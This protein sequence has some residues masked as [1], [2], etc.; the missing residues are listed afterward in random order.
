VGYLTAPAGLEYGGFLFYADDYN[1]YLAKMRQG[2]EGAWAYR[3]PYTV[4]EHDGGA[5]YL[6]YLV[7]GRLAA[8][9]GL[10]LV[11]VWHLARWVC[12][13]VFLLTVY[14]FL[15]AFLRR[16]TQRKIAYLLVCFSAGIGWLLPLVGLSELD[17]T[18][19]LDLW[20]VEGYAFL[21]T[22][23]F[24]HFALASALLIAAIALGGLAIRQGRLRTALWAGLAGL[25]LVAVQP[26]NLVTVAG[27][28]GGYWLL[29][30]MTR[31]RLVWRGFVALLLAGLIPLPLLLYDL[32]VF[33]IDPV[34]RA[35]AQ[36]NICLSPNPL[37]YLMAYG[38][39]W[40][41]ALA[42]L[43]RCVR[44]RDE[45]ELLIA[46]WLVSGA[47]VLYAPVDFQR[48]LV[49]GLQI[50]ICILATGGLFYYVLPAIG[51]ARWVSVLTRATRA[52]YNRSSLRR[53]A[54]NGLLV[55]CSVTSLALW[56]IA[57]IQVLAH[58]FPFYHEM[59]ENQALDWLATRTARSDAVLASYEEANYIPA[60]AGNRVYAGHWAE[61]P[62]IREKI[63]ALDTF[64]AA[65]T[66]DDWR[67][68]FLSE[69]DIRYLMQGPRE[70]ALGGFDPVGRT[71]LTERFAVPGFAIYQVNAGVGR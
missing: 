45:H 56:A 63:R 58:S 44:R 46:A 49:Q 28:L 67:V 7:L 47:L 6:F 51:R 71:Y 26:Y 13:L 33:A 37:H 10:S 22:M 1:S 57:N 53:F 59:A 18:M 52:R 68:S 2:A 54:V 48:R 39:L 15:S 20:V 41:L 62:L 50:P 40:P 32:Y 21:S 12:G 19:P 11:A 14:W 25:T 9:T 35:W 36:G 27:V 5:V 31:R 24:P 65:Q 16:R 4:Q 30:T 8:A 64:Y 43:W 38:L 29:L 23:T 70:R 34:Y 69:N 3:I 66:S 17:G 42:G 60:R 55:F 61:T